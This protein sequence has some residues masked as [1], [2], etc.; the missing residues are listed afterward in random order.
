[1]DALAVCPSV[2]VLPAAGGWYAVVRLPRIMSDEQMVTALAQRFG[3]RVHPG[4]FYDFPTDGYAVVSLIL[5]PE[6]FREGSRRLAKGLAALV[7][8]A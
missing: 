5:P 7:A 2:D 3:V 8:E 4:F 6:L 1:L